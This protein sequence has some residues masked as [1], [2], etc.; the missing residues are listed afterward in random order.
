M[1]SLQSSVFLIVSL[2]AI[3]LFLSLTHLAEREELV[4]WLAIFAMAAADVAAMAG[5]GLLIVSGILGA[6]AIGQLPPEDLPTEIF[7]SGTQAA[8]QFEAVIEVMPTLGTVFLVLGILGLGVL[9]PPVRKLVARAIP[10]DPQRVV[11]TAAL[12]LVLLLVAV[13]ALTAVTVG[14]VLADEA[15]IEELAEASEEGGLLQLW[16]QGLGFVIA[17]FLGVGLF[18]RRGWRESLERLGITSAFS[19]RW[20]LAVTALGLMSGVLIDNLWTRFQPESM[21]QVERLTE[22]LFGPYL[23]AGLL[24]ALTIGLSA[25]IGEEIIF[26]GAAQPR[27]GLVFT[28]LLFAGL[29]VQYTISPALIQLLIMGLL[30][31]LA[32]RRVNT[33]TAI[34]A[35]ASYNF[36]LVALAL[37]LPELGP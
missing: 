35:H 34:A 10:I 16:A 36:L 31:G 5:G 14:V 29:H 3:G 19:I 28:S 12:H 1:E 30:L 18:I 26:R 33:T 37:Y 6:G 20:W 15:L 17:G 32:R 27:L 11:H 23:E 4:K 22:A 13:S 2:G 21:D 7:P 9:L 8:D 24:G 25:G